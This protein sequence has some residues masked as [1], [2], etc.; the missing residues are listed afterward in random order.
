MLSACFDIWLSHLHSPDDPCPW[1]IQ[2][3]SFRP[4]MLLRPGKVENL[5]TMIVLQLGTTVGAIALSMTMYCGCHCQFHVF[6]FPAHL[7][8]RQ[9]KKL[10]IK[11][12]I[13]N[14]RI[15][16][17]LHHHQRLGVCLRHFILGFA[18]SKFTICNRLRNAIR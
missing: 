3:H 17:A 11:L 7:I 2:P 15:R 12:W 16:I 5:Q 6:Y 4:D 13:F 18:F 1:N 10:I 8:A 9:S 14:G